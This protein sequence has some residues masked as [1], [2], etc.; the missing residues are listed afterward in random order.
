MPGSRLKWSSR[1]S[2]LAA[3]VSPYCGRTG[4]RGRIGIYELMLVNNK[5]RN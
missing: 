4:Y 5:L 2:S 1:L 3:R